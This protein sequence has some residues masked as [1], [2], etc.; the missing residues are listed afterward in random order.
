MKTSAF[1]LAG[2][3][4]FACRTLPRGEVLSPQDL[5]LIRADSEVFAAVVHPQV[6][7]GAKVQLFR[8]DSLRI[9]P[10]PYGDPQYF[11]ETAGG[12]QGFD[13][14]GLFT[15]PD[16]ALMRRLVQSRSRILKSYGV[17]EGKGF[18]YPKCGGT[19]SPPPPPPPPPAAG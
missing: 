10:R 7:P 14:S 16:S 11:E 9:D 15:H 13:P 5:A 4:L 19:L 18:Y 17:P 12:S 8:Y 6:E 1:I 2:V 3:I